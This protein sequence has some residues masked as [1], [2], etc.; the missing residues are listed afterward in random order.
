[1]NLPD[2]QIKTQDQLKKK[3]LNAITHFNELIDALNDKSLDQ[4]NVDYIKEHITV[5]KKNLNYNTIKK[6]E[7]K[8]LDYIKDKKGYVAKN[9]YMSLWIA[10]GMSAIGVPIGVTIGLALDQ[11]G[12]MGIGIG[13]GLAMGIGIGSAKDNKAKQ[14]GKQLPITK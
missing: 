4:E 10:L 13:S 8:I 5:I 6:K 11:L 7:S 3:D 2:L 9:H 1:M 14:E 12:F